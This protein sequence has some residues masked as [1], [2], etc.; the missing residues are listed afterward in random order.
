LLLSASFLFYFGTV[1]TAFVVF[2][3]ILYDD[4]VVFEY[5]PS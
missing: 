4:N 5:C 1:L 3:L 2:I